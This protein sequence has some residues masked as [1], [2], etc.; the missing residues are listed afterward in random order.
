MVA[1]SHLGAYIASLQLCVGHREPMSSVESARV[2]AGF[3][4]EGDRHATSEGVRAARQV[5]VMDEE[6]LEAFSLAHGDVRENITTSGLDPTFLEE[7]QRL[8]LGG[9]V[10]LQITGPCAPCARMD[11]IRPGLRQEL[12]GRRGLLASVVRGGTIRVGDAI[13]VL[14]RA[15]AS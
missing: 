2:V 12:E 7:G 11:E 8:A 15:A 5:L 14:E 13:R 10:V 9:Q 6:T 4:I 1:R 3:G